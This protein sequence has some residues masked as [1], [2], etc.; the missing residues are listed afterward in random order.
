L[1]LFIGP[2]LM[3]LL[4]AIWREWLR[5]VELADETAAGSAAEIEAGRRIEVL[6]EPGAAK[7]ASA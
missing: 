5:E 7:K 1:G 6:P 2:V 3:A 4:V